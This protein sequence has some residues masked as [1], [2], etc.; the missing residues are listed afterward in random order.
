MPLLCK[1]TEELIKKNDYK[2]GQSIEPSVLLCE[3]ITDVNH[4][5]SFLEKL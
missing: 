4:H 1:Q 2:N 3:K 5:D